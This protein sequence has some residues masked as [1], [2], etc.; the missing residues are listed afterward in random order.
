M[1]ECLFDK[2]PSEITQYEILSKLPLKSLLAV[3]RCSKAMHEAAQTNVNS[4]AL[5]EFGIEGLPRIH[6]LNLAC[7]IAARNG[8]ASVWKSLDSTRVDVQN[9]NLYEECEQSPLS[10]VIVIVEKYSINFQEPPLST[11]WPL[12]EMFLRSRSECKLSAKYML[13]EMRAGRF[14]AIDCPC[15]GCQSI[16]SLLDLLKNKRI[17]IWEEKPRKHVQERFQD[18][19][20]GLQF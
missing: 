4:A 3:S 10:V 13:E 18:L 12:V 17:L 11:T 20:W 6:N 1:R 5:Q 2:I 19:L 14:D 15:S 7:K 9:S 16:S 8:L